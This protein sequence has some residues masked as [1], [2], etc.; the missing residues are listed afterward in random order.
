MG[1]VGVQLYSLSIFRAVAIVLVVLSHAPALGALKIDTFHEVAFWNFVSGATTLFVF[2]SGFLF[3]HVFLKRFA[4]ASFFTKKLLNLGIPY[5]VLTFAALAIGCQQPAIV[6]GEGVLRQVSLGAFM[7]GTGHGAVS[8]WYIPFV[9]T[10]F[11]M[12]PLHVRF[13][14]LSVRWQMAT[15][16][17]LLAIALLVH[18]P[19]QNIGALQNLIYYTPVYLVGVFCSQHRDA[20][21]PVISRWMWLLL[22]AVLGLAAF[23]AAIGE[24]GNYVK[25]MLE[26][27]GIDLLLVQKLC[28]ALFLLSFLRRFEAKRSRIID[29]VA[30]TSFAT[31]FLHPLFIEV[32]IDSPFTAP[33]L[34]QESWVA[35]FV[36]SGLCVAT[37]AAGALWVRRLFGAQS[38]L[39]TGY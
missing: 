23:Q 13:T 36:V 18:R 5:V 26:F 12:A 4:F 27:R 31:F 19:P 35:Y 21:Y 17:V 2:I 32:F 10:L 7:L 15:L 22:A 28:L 1:V 33:L 39:L 30:D 25:P 6:Q 24:Y 38:R 11:A 34:A 8:Y 3:H 9:I 16:V 37:C 20:V 14:A 29:I